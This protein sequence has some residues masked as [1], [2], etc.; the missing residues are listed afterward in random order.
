MDSDA[1][2][3]GSATLTIDVSSMTTNWAEEMG[4]T[5]GYAMGS[6]PAAE[7]TVGDTMR[8][9]G[10]EFVGD[11][12]DLTVEQA[13]MLP[14]AAG[15]TD[16]RYAFLVKITGL[17]DTGLPYNLREFSLR[18]DQDFEYDAL[19]SGGQEPRLE[20]GDLLPN[21]SVRGWLTFEVPH[22]TTYVDLTYWPTMGLEPAIVRV[23]VESTDGER[24][25][26]TVGA[27]SNIIEASWQAL[28]DGYVYGLLHRP[29]VQRAAP[30][31]QAHDAPPSRCS[32]AMIAPR[33]PPARAR[34]CSRRASYASSVRGSASRPLARLSTRPSTAY[35]MRPP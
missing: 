29:A 26:N 27:S 32:P 34:F 31:E 14:P 9:S 20:F 4:Y 11:Q 17:D 25:W 12:A 5:I 1:W 10:G 15:T 3:D 8:V 22:A 28:L 19:P 24:H 2:I 7:N 21:Q 23:L 35:A 18:D 30:D 33:M 13:M 6:G 16:T